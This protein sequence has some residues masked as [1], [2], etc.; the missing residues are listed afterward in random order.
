VHGPLRPLPERDL[1][2]AIKTVRMDFRSPA[3]ESWNHYSS[4]LSLSGTIE[5]PVT[6]TWIHDIARDTDTG[7]NFGIEN[8]DPAWTPDGKRIAYS[9]YRDDK[10]AIFWKP[11]DG[12]ADAELLLLND[13]PVDAW[14]FSPD[15]N[16]L[17]YADWQFE[18][19]LNVG[20]VRLQDR[21][22]AKL[23]FPAK[24]NV[25][26]AVLSPDGKWI[27]YDS[28]ETGKP[29]VY[30]APYPV[31]ERS[32][33]HFD[34]RRICIR[35]RPMGDNFITGWEQPRKIWSSASWDRSRE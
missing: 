25:E 31:L 28:D 12:S 7:F 23:I 19:A 33:A 24:Y 10:H 21:Q 16:T 2:R 27:A 8:R 35:W 26:W 29:E 32:R 15:G 5:G 4:L 17:L 11:L 30:V 6:N 1:L 3:R 20:A 34:R 13:H 9:G 22:Q 14:F 18:G